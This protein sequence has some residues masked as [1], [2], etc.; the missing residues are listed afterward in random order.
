MEYLPSSLF[1][2][3]ITLSQIIFAFSSIHTI[4]KS[5]YTLSSRDPIGSSDLYSDIG[6]FELHVNIKGASKI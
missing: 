6:E 4:Q 5:L 3:P 1:K 2:L